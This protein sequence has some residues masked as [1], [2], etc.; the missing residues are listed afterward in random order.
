MFQ[1]EMKKELRR[2]GKIPGFLVLAGVVLAFLYSNLGIFPE[3]YVN[4]FLVKIPA[5]LGVAIG[6]NQ[7]MKEVYF[8]NATIAKDGTFLG[9]VFIGIMMAVATLA[10]T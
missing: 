5:P 1:E 10:S 6:I 4:T 8:K 3:N 7:I 9:L 2:F